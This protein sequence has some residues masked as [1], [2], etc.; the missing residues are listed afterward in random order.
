VINHSREAKNFYEAIQKLHEVKM[1]GSN[2][3]AAVRRLI[4]K[5][6]K[7]AWEVAWWNRRYCGRDAI[8]GIIEFQKYVSDLTDEEK[9]YYFL[10]QRQITVLATHLNLLVS[11]FI[12]GCL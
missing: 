2:F 1:T 4:T 6:I 10:V 11:L 9:E 12:S 8:Q 5:L 3:G 7:E